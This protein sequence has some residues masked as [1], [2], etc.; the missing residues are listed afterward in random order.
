MAAPAAGC[1]TAD[2]M[3]PPTAAP[4]S[5]PMPAP[6]SLVVREP[7]AQ[8]PNS[9][10]AVSRKA[11]FFGTVRGF[12]IKSSILFSQLKLVAIESGQAKLMHQG[13]QRAVARIDVQFYVG[14]LGIGDRVA[15]APLQLTAR[16]I[17][18]GGEKYCRHQRLFAIDVWDHDIVFA[19][20]D[21]FARHWRKTVESL[22]ILFRVQRACWERRERQQD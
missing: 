6:F 16:D 11:V 15:G 2:P 17:A 22:P 12:F 1:P 8:P 7:L 9:R 19:E 13:D 10:V 21:H 20:P 14:A 5:A 4:P 18:G 3:M